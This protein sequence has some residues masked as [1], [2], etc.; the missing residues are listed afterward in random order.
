MSV[1]YLCIEQVRSETFFVH[2]IRYIY[3]YI[4]IYTR[5]HTN[6]FAS[7]YRKHINITFESHFLNFIKNYCRHS[8]DVFFLTNCMRLIILFYL[9]STIYI[10]PTIP[11]CVI[12]LV[13]ITTQNNL[14]FVS[15]FRPEILP[16]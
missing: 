8:R 7:T 16:F 1:V 6:K 11:R 5:T 9:L 3:I 2:S 15:V 13:E 12:V 4:Y 10:S 14:Y